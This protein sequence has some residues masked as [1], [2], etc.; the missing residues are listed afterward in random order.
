MTRRDFGKGTFLSFSSWLVIPPGSVFDFNGISEIRSY[1]QQ[2]LRQ[3]K[4]ELLRSYH[5]DGHDHLIDEYLEPIR[6][7]YDPVIESSFHIL[8]RYGHKIEFNENQDG[9]VRFKITIST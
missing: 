7:V 4:K 9:A 5:L 2:M 8:N 1:H 3:S 6:Y